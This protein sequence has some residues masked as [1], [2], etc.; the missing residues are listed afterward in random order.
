MPEQNPLRSLPAPDDHS[1][2]N[3][4][5]PADLYQAPAPGWQP[6][7]EEAAVPLTHY[8]WILKR[9]RWKI[10]AFVV[11]CV[12]ATWIVSQRITPVYEATATVDVDR[13][14]PAGIIGQEATR[15]ALNDADQFLAT[16]VKLIQSDSV[17]RPVAQRY[18]LLKREEQKEENSGITPAD[19]ENAPVV[20]KNLKVTRP[21]NTYLLL[22]S[23]RST[24]PRL[25]ANVANDIANSYLEHTYLI[26]I[27]SSSN[28]S[29]FM[30]KQI[31][32]LRAKMEASSLKLAQFERDLNVINPE[33]KTN[34]LSAR[35]LQLNTEYT[36][37]QADRLKKEAA[38]SSVKSGS[39][40]AA[41]VSAQGESLKKITERLEDAQQ[42][43]A[44]I[45][46]H[47]GVAHPEYKKASAQLVELQRQLQ[48]TKENIARRVEVE[49]LEVAN[50]ELMLKKAV[51]ETKAE[52][53]RLNARSFEYQS[54][55]RDAEND[56][57][58]YEELVRKIREAGINAGFQNN[59]IRLAD[60]AR[61]PI[62]PV[63]PNLPLNLALAFLFSTLL[64]VG[65]AIT[66]DLLSTTVR[67]PEMITRTL[68]TDVIG[69]L[70]LAKEWAGR[71]ASLAL[72]ASTSLIPS[73]K[74]SHSRTGYDEAIRT[75]RNAILLGDFDRRIRSLMITSTAPMEGKS[76]VA[77]TLATAH[78][79]HGRKTLLIDCDQRRPS[80]HRSFDC[81]NTTGLSDVLTGRALWR[82]ALTKPS[83][84]PELD[85]LLGGPHSRRAIDLIGTVLPDVLDE[86]GR[87]YDLVILDSPPLLGFPEPLQMATTADGVLLV[88]LPG[89]TS[90]K[91]LSM[92]V[93]TLNRVR[94][95]IVGIVMNKVPADGIDGY[96][97]SYYYPSHYKHYQATAE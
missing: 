64:A 92:A 71:K 54:L 12:A 65:A 11:T 80:V 24:D 70:P 44:D 30:E 51:A 88:A 10:L 91:A 6:E 46:I 77:A 43:F 66:S 9:H 63:F 21:P 81:A 84:V 19:R 32:E 89:Q 68:K 78:A 74:K 85:L 83:D 59:A 87:E 37:A 41:Q 72:S 17:L 86:A 31:E 47:Y 79:Q 39:L 20:L 33:E 52:F 18:S 93:S 49:Y 45:K 58:L 16:Q 8:L 7:P 57:K 40:E 13:Q 34:I 42:K 94:A 48:T 75:L 69:T 2:R 14:T 38:Y 55:K 1:G 29:A 22:I 53:D 76:T 23:Y 26:R 35:L 90:R 56:K 73:E 5:V 50:R 3:L 97:Y 4:P 61:P 82:D 27:R 60:S 95:N 36:A 96:Y 25:A 15:A 28:L 62:R 67:D